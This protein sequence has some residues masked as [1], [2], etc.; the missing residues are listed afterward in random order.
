MTVVRKH[1]RLHPRDVVRELLAGPR[2][3]RCSKTVEDH[4]DVRQQL[5]MAEVALLRAWEAL[6]DRGLSN[7][8]SDLHRVYGELRNLRRRRDLT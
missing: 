2:N 3:K 8:A 4:T 1:N 7:T 5:D 6:R